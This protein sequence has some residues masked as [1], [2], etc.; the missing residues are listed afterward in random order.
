M[1]RMVPS[2]AGAV[3]PGTRFEAVSGEGSVAGMSR[4]KVVPCPGSD[5]AEMAPSCRLMI[6]KL[7]TA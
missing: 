4:V 1:I 6:E 2:Q 7:E 3:V 5:L